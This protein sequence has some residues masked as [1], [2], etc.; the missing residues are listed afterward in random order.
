MDKYLSKNKSTSTSTPT[1]TSTST[2][3]PTSTSTSTSTP[4]QITQKPLS[5]IE[6]NYINSLSD[7]EL[8][9]YHIANQHLKTSF[10]LSKSQGY[11]KWLKNAANA[12]PAN[13]ATST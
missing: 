11:R 2:S 8:K 7:K 9:A 3:T 1:S 5:T 4:Q 6:T 10:E 12:A 13:T